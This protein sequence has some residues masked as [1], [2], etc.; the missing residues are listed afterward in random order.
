[1]T[2]LLPSQ[3][4]L[5]ALPSN[6]NVGDNGTGGIKSLIVASFLTIGL[7][8]IY[9]FHFYIFVCPRGYNTEESIVGP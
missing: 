4:N 9:F 5:P 1:M 3:S 7:R 8:N 6:L 2:L